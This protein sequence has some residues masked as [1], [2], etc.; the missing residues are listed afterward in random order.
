EH[1]DGSAW[2]VSVLDSPASDYQG[3]NAIAAVSADDI[4]AVGDG[5]SWHWGGTHWAEEG[6]TPGLFGLAPL[7]TDDVWAV[8]YSTQHWNGSGWTKIPRSSGPQTQFGAVAFSP[9][10]VWAG[11]Y[12]NYN[13]TSYV[14]L[15][16]K[17]CPAVVADAGFTPSSVDLR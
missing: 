4:W 3:L 16:S 12:P 10:D 17:F 6:T 9:Q 14:G 1:W 15:A 13:G 11:G 2:T 5:E 7:A 8:G